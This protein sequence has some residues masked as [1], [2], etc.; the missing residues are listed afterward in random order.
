[1]LVVVVLERLG[2][3]DR[4]EPGLD[5]RTVIAAA[6]EAIEAKHHPH[7]IAS[8]NFLHRSRE[9]AGRGVHA[10]GASS[11]E[12]AH[13]MGSAGSEVRADDVVVQEA[14][15]PV[16]L[17]LQVLEEALSAE[18]P[19]LLPRDR[20]EE[21]RR[22]ERARREEPRALDRDRDAGRVVVRAGRVGFG[23]HDGGG[24]RVIV[25]GDEKHASGERPV[26]AGEESEHVL[27]PRGYVAGAG[28]SRLE[29][30]DADVE[31]AAARLRNPTQPRDEPVAAASDPALR[32]L[33]GGERVTSAA[34]DEILDRRAQGRLVDRRPRDRSGR[35]GGP[36]R[37]GTTWSGLGWIAGSRRSRRGRKRERGERD[38]EFDCP[39]SLC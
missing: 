18:E 7:R 35:R 17:L 38:C 2:E 8:G 33:P 11:R 19:L 22:P 24:H 14:A 5:E 1:V 30:V 25:T 16:A 26:A 29:A 28:A 23:V 32:V 21:E 6:A 27:E 13:A 34:P 10:V 3:T 15:H 39:K 9:V 12:H 20:R 4:G 31:P 36:F 37:G